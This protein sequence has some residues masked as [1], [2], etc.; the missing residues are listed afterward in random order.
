MAAGLTVTIHTDSTSLLILFRE[1]KI[2]F[3]IRLDNPNYSA[4]WYP[5]AG[6][7]RNVWLVKASPFHIAQWGTYATTK[8]VSKSSATIE[9]EVTIGNNSKKRKH[10]N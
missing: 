9:L 7:Y 3:T 10:Q 1:A 8:E 2:N 6:I 5:G 4:R